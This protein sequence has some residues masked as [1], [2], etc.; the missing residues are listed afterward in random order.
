MA[1]QAQVIVAPE[2]P[3]VHGRDLLDKIAPG[4]EMGRLLKRAYHIQIEQG[5]TDKQELLKRL[6]E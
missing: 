5:I 3:V 4:P 6:F 1:Q 2:E